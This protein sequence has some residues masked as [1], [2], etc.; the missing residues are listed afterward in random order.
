MQKEI[1]Q[2]WF[3]KQSPQKVWEYLTKPELIEQWLMKNDFKPIVGHKFQFTFVPKNESKYDGIVDCE[4]LA[5]KPFVKLS[6]SWNGNL[7]DGSRTFNSKV[8]W[9][10]I[11]KENGTELQLLH[12]GFTILEDI[13]NHTNGWVICIKRFEELINSI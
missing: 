6:Y 5:V 3:F 4:V 1:K 10:L 11:P 13:L 7:K 12:N 8:V 9:T 2:T